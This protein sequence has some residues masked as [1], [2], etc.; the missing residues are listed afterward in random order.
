MAPDGSKSG[1]SKKKSLSES[2]EKALENAPTLKGFTI[3]Q[4]AEVTKTP[5]PTAR[6]HLELLEARGVV[7]HV[8][9]GRAKLYYLKKDAESEK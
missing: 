1:K 7:D 4:V 2:I 5:W 3:K 6:W 8:D 9:I